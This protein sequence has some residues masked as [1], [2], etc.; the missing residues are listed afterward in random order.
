MSGLQTDLCAEFDALSIASELGSDLGWALQAEI[1]VFAFLAAM[2]TR[3]STEEIDWGYE[4]VATAERLPYSGLLS[5]AIEQLA[6]EGHLLLDGEKV[7]V[8][9]SGDQ[10]LDTYMR[11][12]LLSSRSRW[13]TESLELAL[14]SQVTEIRQLVMSLPA[15]SQIAE[16]RSARSLRHVLPS[17]GD[18]DAA[19]SMPASLAVFAWLMFQRDVDGAE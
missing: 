19:R 4:F 13:L 1:Q 8:S 12:N 10:Q 2:T 9:A 5:E 17:S 6:F 11:L 7:F 3:T 16:M 14:F 15:M 18:L